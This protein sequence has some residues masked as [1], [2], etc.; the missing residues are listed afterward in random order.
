[1]LAC[2][3]AHDGR[4]T[5][6][7]RQCFLDVCP[8]SNYALDLFTSCFFQNCQLCKGGDECG[9]C[10]ALACGTQLAICQSAGC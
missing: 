1:V 4:N 3:N 7:G 9:T 8:A 10:F 2:S 6:E 5:P